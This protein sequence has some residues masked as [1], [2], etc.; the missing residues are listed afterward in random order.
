[1]PK[2]NVNTANPRE[3]VE[4]RWQ[5]A[6]SVQLGTVH[7]TDLESEIE[8]V[9]GVYLDLDRFGIN[10]LITVLRRARDAAFGRDA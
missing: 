4:V 6:G 1:M 3:R 8:G 7:R 2:E 5:H 9:E 10:R